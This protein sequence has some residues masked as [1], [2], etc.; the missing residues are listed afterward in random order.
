[1]VI[2][3]KSNNFCLADQA[4][5]ITPVPLVDFNVMRQN[6]SRMAS[7]TSRHS[8]RLRPHIKTHKSLVV[9]GAQ[10]AAGAVGIT[11]ATPLEA[12]VMAAQTA[13]ILVAYPSIGLG[14]LRRLMEL[15]PAT[16]LS[17]AI[18]SAEALT[19]LAGSVERYSRRVKVLI[20][21]DLGMRR[22]G[23]SDPNAIVRLA[24]QIT[25][26][27]LLEFAGVLFYPGHIRSSDASADQDLSVLATTLEAGLQ[28]LEG[29]GFPVPIVSGGSTPTAW[30]SHELERVTEIR[31]GTYVFNDRATVAAGAAVLQ[32][33]ALTILTTVVSTSVPGQVVIDAGTKALGRE[34]RGGG[35]DWGYGEVMEHPGA[36]V[37]RM[38]EEHG[39]IDLDSCDWRPQVGELVRIIPNHVCIAMHLFDHVY[40]VVDGRLEQCWAVAARGR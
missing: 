25:G 22:T 31:P 9:A 27:Q 23:L 19:A 4:D 11:C 21:L 28:V 30:R 26:H 33:C 36:I 20:E 35:A 15:P 38:S 32:D 40:A 29:A 37:T 3:S 16:T 6:I 39:I 1:M 8:L 14:R 7:Y 17:V 5:V 10:L 18:D 12:A 2:D 24:A 13:D 34:P